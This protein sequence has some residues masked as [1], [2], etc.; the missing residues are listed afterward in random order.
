MILEDEFIESIIRKHCGFVG[1]DQLI[2]Y[3]TTKASCIVC[4][5]PAIADAFCGGRISRDGLR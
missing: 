2:A 3:W 5:L 4:Q 1:T